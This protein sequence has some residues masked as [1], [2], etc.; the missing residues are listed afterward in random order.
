MLKISKTI[1]LLFSFIFLIVLWTKDGQIQAAP[2]TTLAHD[3]FQGFTPNT[4]IPTSISD[5]WRSTGSTST[6][7]AIARESVTNNTY[8][9]ISNTHASTGAY[10]GKPFATA[11]ST[12][13]VSEFDLNIPSSSSTGRLF[14]YDSSSLS[15]GNITFRMDL[16]GG[17]MKVYNGGAATTVV[18]GYSPST[19]YHFKLVFDPENKRFNFTITD[20]STTLY[21]SSSYFSF[22]SSAAT[23]VGSLSFMPGYNGMAMNVDNVNV[24]VP[25]YQLDVSG[26]LALNVQ[27]IQT[28]QFTAAATDILG[29]SVANPNLVWSVYD[30]SN[31]NPLDSSLGITIS[32]NGLLTVQGS[33][34]PIAVNVRAANAADPTVF[35]SRLVKIDS[36]YL[37]GLSAT[38]MTFNESFELKK[39]QYSSVVGTSVASA[40]IT[41]TSSSS[42]NTDIT[43]NGE[44][45]A[46]GVLSSPISLLPGN[47][48][49]TVKVASKTFPEIY[50]TYTLLVSQT[51]TLSGD[52]NLSELTL[53]SGTLAFSSGTTSYTTSVD[54]TV[55]S[56]NVTLKTSNIFAKVTVNSVEMS[57]QT[58]AP[59]PLQV[60]DNIILIHV[61]AQ[62][63]T[64]KDYTITVNRAES[65]NANLSN[66]TL[67]GG[68]LNPNFLS[69]TTTYTVNAANG[70]VS[71]MVTP[72]TENENATITVQG[73]TVNRGQASAP[74]PLQLGSNLIQVTVTAQDGTTTKT[75]TLDVNKREP[76][77]SYLFD[78]GP[79]PVETG[80]TGVSCN[81]TSL[82]NADMGYGWASVSGLDGRDRGAPTDSLRR[83]FCVGNAYSFK[84]DL[85][86]GFYKVRAI[87]GDATSGLSGM[88]ILTEGQTVNLSAALGTFSTKTFFVELLDGQMNL[89]ISGSS[90]RINALEISAA[91]P[92][93]IW[94]ST[95]LSLSDNGDGTVTLQNSKVSLDIIKTS[96]NITSIRYNGSKPTV[97]LG[98]GSYLANY[99][100]NGVSG[101][102]AMNGATFSIVSQSDERIEL[103]FMVHDPN[104]LPFQLDIRLV[105]E[106]DSPGLYYYS[107]YKYT[108]DM[109]AGLNMDQLRYSFSPPDS[110]FRNYVVD[111]LRKGTY[112]APSDLSNGT[113][114]QDA[115]YLLADGTVYTKYQQI[116]S[117]EG[118]N[119]VFGVYG[120]KIGMSLI[121]AN[122]DYFV[123][124]PTK[125]EL[126][127]HTSTDGPKLLF[128]EFTGHYGNTS[129]NPPVGWEKVYG[130]FYL[131]LNEGDSTDAMWND[132][133]ARAEQEKSKWPYSWVTD[134]LY[135]A[136][137]RGNATGKLTVTDGSSAN[138]A[139]VILAAGDKD[140]QLQNEKYEYYVH[141]ASDGSFNIPAVR[142]GE[143]TLY[144]VV[145]GVFDEFRKEHVV[146]HSN[147]TTDL[148]P[149][150]WVPKTNGK[151][152]WQIG[153]PDRSAAE[154]Y[155][156]PNASPSSIPN[157]DKYRQFG[158]WLEYPLEFPNGVDFKV[159]L[160]D[161]SKK[162]NFFQPASK[163]PG[164]P[165]LLKVPKDSSPAIWKIR[166]DSD[167]YQPGSGTGTMTF[168]LAGNVYGSLL[169]KLNGVEIGRW[170]APGNLTSAFGDGP[171]ND[172][173]LYRQGAARGIYHQVEAVFDAGLIHQGENV[174]ELSLPSPEGTDSWTNVNTSIM[175]DAIRLEVDVAGEKPQLEALELD[176]TSYSLSLGETHQTVAT[177]VYEDNTR[178][179]V[180]SQVSFSS[181]NTNVATVS[182]QGLVTAVGTGTAIVTSSMEGVSVDITITVIGSQNTSPSSSSS[183][184]NDS[185]TSGSESKKVTSEELLKSTADNKISISLGE[186]EKELLFPIQAT[187]LL[188][189]KSI[190][191]KQEGVTVA[192]PSEILKSLKQLLP[193]NGDGNTQ[194]V[195]KVDKIGVE[196]SKTL[197]GQVERSSN[198]NI[199]VVSGIYE[200]SLAAIDKD[201]IDMKLQHFEKPVTLTFKVAAD[202]NVKLVGVYYIDENG[203]LEYV[204]GTWVNGELRADV[205]HFSKYMVL[206]YDKAFL[207]VPASHWAVETVKE[208]AAK[209]VIEG[210]SDTQFAPEQQVTRAQ[211]V[212]M[213][214]RSLGVKENNKVAPFQDIDAS[215]WYTSSIGVAYK[216][217]LIS[218]RTNNT[219]DP[220]AW[221]TREEIASIIVHAYE[222]KHGK[223]LDR[224]GSPSINFRDAKKISA[225]ADE[226]VNAAIALKLL[227][228][229]GAKEFAPQGIASRAESAKVI[230]NLMNN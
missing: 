199:K 175:Y 45:A 38:N 131:Y 202:T 63:G 13:F 212:S 25:N 180:T 120:D 55:T 54:N 221:I 14:Y 88:K 177:A 144:A 101:Q 56:A 169:V 87:A 84:V 153:T 49:V 57:D 148:G 154:F 227:Q 94:G 192:L 20:G 189:S 207:D 67:S 162:W 197:I 161:P 44:A 59:I 10:F 113:V 188:G 79:S 86:N 222:W 33:S 198:A 68:V 11:Q 52:A 176:S 104:Q 102:K 203:G 76:V 32:N 82:Y 150:S 28:A 75:Y 187:E 9:S 147:A 31:Q 211:F 226:S 91:A 143:Y 173:S 93:D 223:K 43:I 53:S 158:T 92:E 172:A 6:L 121:Q 8:A 117:L 100:I 74:I 164:D 141:A 123:G 213:L 122:K 46:S 72:T 215:A 208:M 130:P 170:E 12:L 30:A 135:A 229:R 77:T 140:W 17:A 78:F 228:G 196:D 151:L 81:A 51:D 99:K 163:T 7:N 103:S 3:D 178:K 160:D 90:A 149:L 219:F 66:L 106:A 40:Q 126:T 23:K 200:F 27:S 35:A 220:N 156:T 83:D 225:W 2:I 138:N 97:N 216:L 18:T 29:R 217:G 114:L 26:P 61:T 201:G 191:I 127:T 50:S 205:Y 184:L 107:I 218:G 119:H 142:P 108:S 146:I 96:A 22:Y 124:G 60:G 134:P 36:A 181:N 105:L 194:L 80:Y 137:S 116:S 139:W 85:P 157:L 195:L 110:V 145:D 98:T 204:G 73:I 62:N 4:I 167:G 21:T 111:D 41:P 71:L 1:I 112:P 182:A 5:Y 89:D 136:S 58:S 132:A 15:S 206:E 185:N 209:H 69:S 48:E 159:G 183:G 118:D 16:G 19:W 109:P 115:T 186:N 125:Q 165:A 214:V 224:S 129:L 171:D 64:T 37:S 133:K 95:A 24:Y 70:A 128:H 166:F 193:M 190:E 210:I 39:F 155:V 179:D 34:L 65:N 42:A 47:N 230:L 174:V 152:L 168:G